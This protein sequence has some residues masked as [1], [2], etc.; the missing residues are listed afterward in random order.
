M[1]YLK[2]YSKLDLK[3]L[4]FR[5]QSSNSNLG[6]NF[7]LQCTMVLDSQNLKKPM[8]ADGGCRKWCFKVRGCWSHHLLDLDDTFQYLK[9][10][11]LKST[12]G[13]E[14]WF[15]ENVSGTLNTWKKKEKN[16]DVMEKK[17]KKMRRSWKRLQQSKNIFKFLLIEKGL[18]ERRTQQSSRRKK[19]KK[20][21]K[22]KTKKKKKKSWIYKKKNKGRC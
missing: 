1:W 22:E 13:R 11:L 15:C 18:L 4:Y 7:Y 6:E 5:Q 16:R 10:V 2:I 9:T 3:Y 14:R 8:W 17:L 12:S 19:R 20:K 21:K